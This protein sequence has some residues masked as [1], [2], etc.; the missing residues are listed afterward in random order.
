MIPNKADAIAS[1]R[2]DAEWVLRGDDLEW[3]D[4]NQTEPTEA[5]I[6]A[7]LARLTAEQPWKILRQ[8]ATNSL[9]K[10]TTSPLAIKP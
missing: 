10:P 5:E 1:L 2:P 3:L 7:E 4:T 9:P 8:R 6:E